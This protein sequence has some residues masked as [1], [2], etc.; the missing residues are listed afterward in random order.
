[1]A[2]KIS[3]Q[4]VMIQD[5]GSRLNSVLPDKVPRNDEGKGHRILFCDRLFAV[6]YSW[7]VGF[8]KVI[9]LGFVGVCLNVLLL[10]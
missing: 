3:R 1:M 8:N 10:F 9:E 6:K 7:L 4:D 2:D 5:L